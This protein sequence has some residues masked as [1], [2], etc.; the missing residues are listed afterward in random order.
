MNLFFRNKRVTGLLTIIPENERNF[1]DE[2]SN[3][4]VPI[5]RSL[6]LKEVM[7]YDK[8]RM[9]EP[10]VCASDLAVLGLQSLISRNL[11]HSQDI[12]AI[13]V[14]T[15]SPDYLMPSTSHVIQG[16]LKLKQDMICMDINQGCAGFVMG[17]IQSYMLLD[18]PAIQKVVLINVDILSS[19]V[20]IQDRNSYPLIGDGA[21]ITIVERSNSTEEFSIYANVKMDGARYDSLIIPA[22][23]F[24]QPSSFK[25]AILHEVEEGNFRALDH[26]HMDGSA[27]FNFVQTEVPKMIDDLLSF[28][29]MKQEEIDVFLFHQPN[30]FMLEKLADKIGVPY[31]KMPMNVVE[32]YGNSS[33]VTIP[34]AITLNYKKK[35]CLENMIACCAGFG[36]GLT[37]ASMIMPLGYLKFC[38]SIE[39]P[40]QLDN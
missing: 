34:I 11:L 37:W 28:S 38:E 7:G 33:G 12:D 31:K 25:T 29:G 18:Q 27:V 14:V 23:G 2:M 26:L 21:S 10:G 24:K 15:Q 9:V 5:S 20:S 13:I 3:F 39:Y 17:L 40:N 19:K 35:L 1:I 6:K 32:K 36:V 30:R 4:D 22:G 8:H 16:R